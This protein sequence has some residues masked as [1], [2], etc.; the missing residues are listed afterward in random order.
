[1]LLSDHPSFDRPPVTTRLWRYT[2]LS[3]FIDLLSCGKLWLSNAEILAS[4]DPFEGTL[5]AVQFPHRMWRTLDEVPEQLRVQI[6]EMCSRGTD[7]TPEAAFR[8][9]FMGEEQR[10]IMMQSGR[11]NYF[12]NCWHASDHESAA[13][14]K[15]YGSPGAGVA[16][17]TNGARLETAL[18]KN[19]EDF[20]LGAVQYRDPSFVQIGCSNAFDT[21]MIKRS[22]YKY[23]QEVRLVHRHTSDFHDAL[24][25]FEWNDNTMRFDNIIDDPRPVVPGKSFNCE[26]DV[27]IERVIVS[28]FAPPWY[29]PMIERVRERFGLRFPIHRST[30]LDAPH[31]LP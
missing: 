12:V 19:S 11:R 30:L 13:M 15:I 6:L 27:L 28:P 5:G 16:I 23:E 3:K 21:I 31:S 8:S 1:M 9:W 22:S 4:D 17:V 24:A 25:N 2:D 14:W 20:Y 10:C 7:G 18:S 26:I 29:A